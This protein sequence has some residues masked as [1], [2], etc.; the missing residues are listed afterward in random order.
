MDLIV[1][2]NFG[3]YLSVGGTEMGFQNTSSEKVFKVK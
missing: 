3:Q 1:G 2:S